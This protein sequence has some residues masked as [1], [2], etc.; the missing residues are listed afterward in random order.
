VY[1]LTQWN[2]T[3]HKKENLAISD[4]MDNLEDIL[5]SEII[6]SQKKK[7]LTHIWN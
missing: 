3:H 1:T 5:L 4:I 6:L 7:N 2:T